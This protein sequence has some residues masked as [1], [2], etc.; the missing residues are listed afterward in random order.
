MRISI[1]TI[2][3]SIGLALGLTQTSVAGLISNPSFELPGG[4]GQAYA[5]GSELGTHDFVGPSFGD[6]DPD[7]WS[8]SSGRIWYM[9][10]EGD[11]EFP[12]G[13]YAV[14]LDARDDVGGIEVLS[15]G[16]LNLVAGQIYTLSL[17][18]WADNANGALLDVGLS[19][20]SAVV[21]H[22]DL[23]TD[24]TDGLADLVSKNFS[25]DVTGVYSL[26]ISSAPNGDNHA[27]V[28]NVDINEIPEPC[29]LALLGVGSLLVVWRRR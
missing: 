2:L 19:G 24:G 15:Q 14:R 12:D 8:R 21:I 29:S 17:S 27:W 16:N 28:D 6:V 3:A 5:A 11:D 13:D 26:D 9:T 4:A 20:A 25:V 22:D 23:A 7:D 1:K 18:Y 10:D